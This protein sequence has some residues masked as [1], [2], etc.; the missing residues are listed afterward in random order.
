MDFNIVHIYNP[1]QLGPKSSFIENKN[2][3]IEE[4]P[5]S[6]SKNNFV[7]LKDEMIFSFLAIKKLLRIKDI[8]IIV[9]SNMPLIP[10]LIIFIYTRIMRINFIFWLQDII[11]IAAKNIFKRQNN[12]LG[13]IVSFFFNFIEF[14]ILRN[15]DHIVTITED[16]NKILIDN[17]VEDNKI[18]CIPNW[19]PIKKIPVLPKNNSFSAKYN[20][21]NTFNIVYSG[22][23]GFKHNPE[24][25]RNLSNFLNK[26]NLTNA[27]IIMISEGPAIEYLKE[28]NHNLTNIIFLPFQDFEIF[29]EVLASADISLVLLEKD[30]GVFSVPSKFLSILCSKRIPVVYVPN[31]NLT[32]KITIKNKCGFSVN[33]DQELFNVIKEVY[34]N[35][36]QFSFLSKNARKYAE[37]H[38]SIDSIANRF[39]YIF[40]N[41]I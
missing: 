40:N 9:S 1:K 35:P 32:A 15:S 25:I 12:R 3:I 7:R 22:T 28:N 41:K 5:K 18:T 8:H 27:K 31:D 29:P 38:F 36:S 37:E 6:F 39:I 17:G 2:L 14:L 10:Q 26:N 30:C 33:S 20:L 23:L 21:E 24:I 19:A 11:S 34:N 4:I 16:F 13:I